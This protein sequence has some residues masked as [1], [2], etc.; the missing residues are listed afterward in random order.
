M[1]NKV[2]PAEV[3]IS[4]GSPLM[5]GRGRLDEI[6]TSCVHSGNCSEINSNKQNEVD[7]QVKIS[8]SGVRNCWIFDVFRWAIFIP[9]KLKQ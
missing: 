4:I 9:K 3:R 1:S 7:Q 8:N 2:D 6:V 5:G